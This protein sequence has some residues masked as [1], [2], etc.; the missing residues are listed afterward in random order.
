VLCGWRKLMSWAAGGQAAAVIALARR[1]TAQ[2]RETGRRDLAGHTGDEIAAALTLTGHAA[3]LL[4]TDAAGLARLPGVHAALSAGAI[5][6]AKAQVF[7]GELSALRDDHTATVIAGT[8]LPDA[9]GL[10]TGQLRARLRRLI[11]AADPEA[12]GRRKTDAQND[13]GVA[14]WPEASG[15]AC[16]AGR[17]LPESGALA[18]DRRLTALARWLSDRGAGG[19]LSQLRA[20]VFLALLTGQPVQSLL[21]AWAPA[22]AGPGDPAGPPAPPVSGTISLTLPLASWAG[23]TGT[24]GEIAG[25]GPAAAG[26]C[27]D[28]A[29]LLAGAAGTRWQL[30]LTSP[31]GQPLATA[32]LA[33]GQGPPPGPAA[34]SWA[35]T[36]LRQLDQAGR[37]DRLE[38]GPGCSHRRAE[39][40]YRPSPRLRNLLICRNRRCSFPGCRRP[41]ITSDLDHT[42]P[43]HLGGITCE[44]NLAP[45]CR[46][47]HKAKQTPGWHLRQTR[48]GILTWTTPAG[49]SYTTTPEPYPV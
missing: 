29:A 4:L 21:P 13:A 2:A 7:T 1:R 30:I 15:N 6:P 49:R 48:P 44:C 3:R 42:I 41:A 20:A 45:L 23:L 28:L 46:Q 18:A 25:Y 34:I 10:T 39:D 9:P 33:P 35:A 37:L 31:A 5:D 47:H 14:L 16:L 22:T 24:A 36:T 17:E 32:A 26:T 11:L 38:P 12:A 8:V 43:W 40:H 27:R 19:S